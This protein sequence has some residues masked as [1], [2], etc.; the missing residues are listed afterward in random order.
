MRRTCLLLAL[1][2]VLSAC[3]LKGPVYLPEKELPEKKAPEKELPEKKVLKKE[4]LP[5]ESKH[6]S[7]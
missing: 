2:S 5:D 7:Q 3:G 6:S 4:H 1:F